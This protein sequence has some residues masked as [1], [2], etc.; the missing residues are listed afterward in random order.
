MKITIKT[1]RIFSNY[2]TATISRPNR[3]SKVSMSAATKKNS[4]VKM[5]KERGKLK[6]TKKEKKLI[7]DSIKSWRTTKKR[8]RRKKK[9]KRRCPNLGLDFM[10]R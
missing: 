1:T 4:T 8:K 9:T 2:V 10:I 5:L 6:L 3:N 7:E